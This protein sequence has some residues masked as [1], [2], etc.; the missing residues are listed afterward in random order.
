[1][2]RCLSVSCMTPP[3]TPAIGIILFIYL[4]LFSSF[5]PEE[6]VSEHRAMAW[7]I[8][9]IPLHLG[10]LL[11]MAAIVVGWTSLRSFQNTVVVSSYLFGLDLVV[12]AFNNTLATVKAGKMVEEAEK[13]RMNKYLSRLRLTPE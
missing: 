10:I 6:E 3:L 2:S 11:L 9:H 4:F 7:E 5:K 1:M 12:D 8:V 13:E